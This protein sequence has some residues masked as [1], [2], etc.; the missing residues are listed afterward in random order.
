MVIDQVQVMHNLG[1]EGRA[2]GQEPPPP[3]GEQ[4]QQGQGGGADDPGPQADGNNANSKT[5]K[6]QH[7]GLVPGALAMAAESDGTIRVSQVVSGKKIIANIPAK[8]LPGFVVAESIEHGTDLELLRVAAAAV[9]HGAKTQRPSQQIG[10][11]QL[12]QLPPPSNDPKGS[13]TLHVAVEPLVLRLSLGKNGKVDSLSGRL[14]LE[15]LLEAP[16]DEGVV[17]LHLSSQLPGATEKHGP[18]AT[19]GEGP[20][21]TPGEGYRWELDVSCKEPEAKLVLGEVVAKQRPTAALR[22]RLPG[23]NDVLAELEVSMVVVLKDPL[24]RNDKMVRL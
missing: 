18:T 15:L 19:S 13:R 16:E 11:K 17:W 3:A 20:C 14:C 24:S 22:L 2:W 9:P 12:V 4:P 10:C 6:P 21:L 1:L 8:S 5:V 7:G 23:S